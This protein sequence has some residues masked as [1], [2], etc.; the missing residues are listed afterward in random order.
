MA[1]VTL[2]EFGCLPAIQK[3]WSN[4]EEEQAKAKEEATQLLE[5]LDHAIKDKKFFGEDSIGLVDIIGNF[6]GYWLVIIAE[7][8]GLKI[9]TQD[10][11]VKENLPPKDKLAAHL[12]AKLP[13]PNASK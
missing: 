5:F 8:A 10:N 2:F 12:R 13:V 9:M 1:Q 4:I 11:F 7:L 3:A 6:V